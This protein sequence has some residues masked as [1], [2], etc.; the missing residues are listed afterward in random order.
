MCVRQ[1]YKVFIC[2]Y[3]SHA[4]FANISPDT[5]VNLL[6]RELSSSS[7]T[8]VSSSELYLLV[9]YFYQV[10]VNRMAG[11]WGSWITLPELLVVSASCLLDDMSYPAKW[12]D[13]YFDVVLLFC[14]FF[15]DC[16]GL[17]I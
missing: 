17:L 16:A 11:I 14:C 13:R 7:T 4:L 9:S 8:A 2:M 6:D 1:E 3:T 5:V 10:Q 15:V 12:R